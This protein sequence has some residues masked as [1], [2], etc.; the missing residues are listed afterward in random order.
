[1]R[2]TP[3]LPLL[4]TVIVAVLSTSCG[5]GG[6][7]GATTPATPQ[8]SG[9]ANVA[10]T[11]PTEAMVVGRTASMTAEAKDAQGAGLAN[12]TITWSSSNPAVASLVATTGSFIEIRAA[13][14]GTAQISAT[15][16]G[17]V[18]SAL[19]TVRA[20]QVTNV[21]IAPV[22]VSLLVG[23]NVGMVAN[24]SRDAEA[25]AAVTWSSADARIAAVDAE[26]RVSALTPGTVLITA[27]SNHDT[28]RRGTSTV[29]VS[30]RPIPQVRSISV[31][32]STGSL[33]VGTTLQISA[34]AQGDAGA[35]L[36]LRYQSSNSAVATVSDRGL[37]LALSSGSTIV[38]VSSVA[39]PAVTQ[40]VIITVAAPVV[41]SITT[42]N[43][44]V[45]VT[46]PL[47]GGTGTTNVGYTV[48]GDP[49]ASNAVTASSS[50]PSIATA[51]A[52]GGTVV[53]TGLAPGA[54]V[55]TLRAVSD[56][57]VL[58]QFNVAVTRATSAVNSVT[59]SHSPISLSTT[60]A[61]LTVTATVQ[62]STTDRRVTFIVSGSAGVF[63]ATPNAD[64]TSATLTAIGAGTGTITA[65]SL[66]DPNVSASTTVTVTAPVQPPPP[67]GVWTLSTSA[68]GARVATVPSV[69]NTGPSTNA[70]FL[71]LRCTGGTQ[72]DLYFST[73]VTKDGVVTY[74]FD[75]GPT[76][77]ETWI[78][79]TTF[80]ALFHPGSPA[81]TR[82]FVT[83]RL[84]TSRQF[85]IAYTSFS[86]GVIA[87]G[88][89]MADPN[90]AVNAVL[91]ACSSGAA[92]GVAAGVKALPEAPPE[93]SLQR[94][95]GPADP[96]K[97]AAAA[98]AHP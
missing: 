30:A 41:R 31:S 24:V 51:T 82:A 11:G 12:R 37:V 66:A 72:L 55:I 83:S 68:T 77:T 97:R 75:G 74:G 81:Q 9:V 5:T 26:G 89:P 65:R 64:G 56:P 1:M 58:T 96:A 71:L 79:S 62:G 21:L 48:A 17:K 85:S 36:S 57:Q 43:S 60:G 86:A 92:A 28:G 44:N 88:F 20:P 69:A 32:P 47:G 49:G 15:S 40:S 94:L 84:Q 6:E 93:A 18:A 8:A 25:S 10:I 90:G 19:V 91:S 34:T 23:D 70:S 73:R 3:A 78:E 98:R 14:V 59:L 38:T 13:G 29:I 52:A 80:T 35:D 4:A 27:T 61:P 54:A 63:S 2:Y 53:V 95:V 33:M 42:N 39:S 76:T 67:A 16:E 87:V 46:L 50:S 45:N 7:G 22:A